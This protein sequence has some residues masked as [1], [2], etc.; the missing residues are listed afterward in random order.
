VLDDGCR[1]LDSRPLRDGEHRTTS[2]RRRA[3]T[4]SLYEHCVARIRHG[5]ASARMACR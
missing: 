2:C 1:F 4:A 5:L 3:E